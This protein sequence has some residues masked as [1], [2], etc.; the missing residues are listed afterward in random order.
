MFVAAAPAERGVSS[1]ESAMATTQQR[2]YFSEQ[3]LPLVGMNAAR[4]PNQAVTGFLSMAGHLYD[5]ELMVVGRAVNGW[6]EGVIPSELAVAPSTTD[7]AATIFD[8]AVG[9][10]PCPM[11]WVTKCWANPLNPDS[12]YNTKKSAFWRVIRAVVAEYG[13]ANTD[14]DTWPSHLVWSNLYKVAPA[15]GGNPSNTLCD[16][17]LPGCISL[18]QQE[19][20]TYLPRR[21]LLLTG[22]NWA[23]PFLENIAPTF[24]PVSNYQYVEAIAEIT[25][26]SGGTS[27]VVVAAHPQGKSEDI[28]VKAVIKAFQLD[29]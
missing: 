29:C 10:G 21:L 27:K 15:E 12:D 11:L 17:Q 3:L 18:L 9:N 2:D 14:E 4:L 28:W 8:S 26:G 24:T 22:L 20:S 13:I 6:A 25:H 19:I 16:I 23:K 7:Y 5:N 1:Q